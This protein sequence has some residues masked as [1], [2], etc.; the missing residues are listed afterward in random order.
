RYLLKKNKIELSGEKISKGDLTEII[1]QQPNYKRL[2]I[3]WK[4]M[5]FNLVDSTKVADKRARKN[6]K[7]FQKNREKLKKQDRINSKR[8]DKARRK[9]KS[10]YTEKLIPL[11]DTLNPK[12]FFR[13]W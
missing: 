4:L 1:R 6:E 13:E 9:G 7:L 10:H 2:G 11:K 5:A 3:K 8:V 12:R